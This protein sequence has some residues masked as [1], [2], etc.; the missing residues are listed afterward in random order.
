[1]SASRIG[2]LVVLA[3]LV[4]ACFLSENIAGLFVKDDEEK[5]QKV[6]LYV[7]FG[8][9]AAAAVIFFAVFIA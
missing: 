3:A 4:A 5:R 1:M 7:K 8:V 9:L 6:S 2:L